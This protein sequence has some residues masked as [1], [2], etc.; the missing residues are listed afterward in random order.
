M[1][2]KKVNNKKSMECHALLDMAVNCKL[3]TA[4][5]E[6]AAL[7]QILDF[8]K[9]NPKESIPK[10]LV[11]HQILSIDNIQF[12]YSVK[13]HIH[14]L[15]V[16]KKFGKLGVA[17]DFVAPEKVKKALELQV[18]IFKK[19]HKSVKIGDI[20]VQNN[21]ISIA[22]K[23]ALLLT[24]DRIK[25]ELLADAL[26]A[27][28]KSE[29][30]RIAISKRFGAIA[31]KRQLIDTTQLNQALKAQKKEAKESEKKRPLGEVFKELFDMPEKDILSILK[32]Q[33]KL[34]TKRMNLERKLLEYNTEKE[35]N[36][37]LGAF[38]EYHVTDDKLQAFVYSIQTPEQKIPLPDFLN[39]FKLS[40]INYGIC[41]KAKLQAFLARNETGGQ[42]QIACGQMPKPFQ[43]ESVEYHFDTQFYETEETKTSDGSTDKKIPFKKESSKISQVPA[44]LV[45]K[46]DIIA[47]LTPHQEAVPGTDVFGRPIHLPE[48]P[49][50]FLAAGQGVM[51]QKNQFIALVPGHPKLFKKRTLFVTPAMD[52]LPTHEIEGDVVD[53]ANEEY[54]A[55]NLNIKGN[56]V[57]G[58]HLA[59][60]HLTIEGDIM[61][62]VTVTGNIEINGGIGEEDP[63]SENKGQPCKVEAKGS[64]RVNQKIIN[65]NI[66]A[67][68]GLNA[69]NSDLVASS[70]TACGD[71][72]LNN[73]F[74]SKQAPSVLRVTRENAI[75]INT[76]IRKMKA[77][78][79]GLNKLN[80]KIELDELTKELMEQIQVQ[81]G[82]LEKQN[83]MLYMNRALNEPVNSKGKKTLSIEQRIKEYEGKTQDVEG[84]QISIP[85]KTK[86]HRFMM[87]I[88][89]KISALNE[90]DQKNYVSE[91]YENISGMY[92][93][94]VK[95][96]DRI[97]KKF[98]ARSKIIEAAVENS[99]KG[100]AKI[101]GKIISL[102]SQKDLLQLEIRKIDDTSK[103]VIRIKNQAGK[104]T[105]IFGERA[106]MIV[107]EPVYRVCLK[108]KKDPSSKKPTIV[109]EDY[110]D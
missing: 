78:K 6:K 2:K 64:I 75:E 15:M 77:L 79:K 53:D 65:A 61:G 13:K 83:V 31:V 50:T 23:T 1:S 68:Q 17:N 25:D 82:Y 108:E 41:D 12:I 44:P 97:N 91:L 8:F 92:K 37:T 60:H 4:E 99:A 57:P 63:G 67:K 24:Q 90:K 100:I 54:L 69:S 34:E 32:I 80:H 46:D 16:D 5:Q 39:W 59:C 47:T 43:N 10:Y 84:K 110:N 52:S 95:V 98:E 106:K 49:V 48:E 40:G 9:K 22:D 45:S 58:I 86:A 11:K 104:Q 51:K 35:S 81:N 33:K 101:Q 66:I 94:A 28:A 27:M 21:D 14:L 7:P 26:N 102:N 76:L 19:R 88:V 96:T 56:I 87:I 62:N 103:P 73:V 18:E 71:I 3:M 70:V 72:V 29:M 85:E 20:L 74:S 89:E 105:M 107:D 93:A 55:S 109:V 42:L 30:E 36:Q 38:Y